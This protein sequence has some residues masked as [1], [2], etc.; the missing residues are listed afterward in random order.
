VTLTPLRK[1]TEK[2]NSIVFNTRK[3]KNFRFRNANFFYSIK[4]K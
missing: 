4:P 2:A 1:S 3:I